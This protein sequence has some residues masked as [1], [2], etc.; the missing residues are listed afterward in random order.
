MN[1]RSLL[2]DVVSLAL[3]KKSVRERICY[4]FMGLIFYPFLW[5]KPKTE[6]RGSPSAGATDDIY[7]LF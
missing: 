6:E 7:P 5:K 2:A 4:L 1:A 3:A